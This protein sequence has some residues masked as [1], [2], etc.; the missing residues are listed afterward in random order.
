MTSTHYPLNDPI[1][2]GRQC[3]NS[4]YSKQ[5]GDCRGNRVDG[6]MNARLIPKCIQKNKNAAPIMTFIMPCPMNRTGLNGAPIMRSIKIKPPT[7]ATKTTGSKLIPPRK[8]VLNLYEGNAGL[9]TEKMA[10]RNKQSFTAIS[11]SSF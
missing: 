3:G 4:R 10:M 7:M 6:D 1:T 8:L 2:N 11:L 5:A 9:R